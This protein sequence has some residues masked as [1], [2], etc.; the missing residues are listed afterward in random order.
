[1][2]VSKSLK[3]ILIG[4]I[5]IVVLALL[6]VAFM[7]IFPEKEDEIVVESTTPVSQEPVYYVIKEDGDS[8]VKLKAIRPDGQELTVHY[9]RDES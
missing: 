5:V 1:M 4:V 2:S 8:L 3:P 7:V 9:N 6:L